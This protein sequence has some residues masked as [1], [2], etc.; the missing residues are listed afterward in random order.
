[1]SI[2]R[3]HITDI[4]IVLIIAFTVCSIHMKTCWYV[5][6]TFKMGVG[7]SGPIDPDSGYAV[8]FINPPTGVIA[9]DGTYADHV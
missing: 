9:T 1:M 4:L 8:Q 7:L 2:K 6:L 5:F 3:Y